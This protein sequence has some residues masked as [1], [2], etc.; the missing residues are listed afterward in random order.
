MKI[1]DCR[2]RAIPEVKYENNG[3]LKY[4]V[5]CSVCHKKTPVCDSLRE[6]V[7]LWNKTQGRALPSEMDS[8]EQDR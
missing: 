2:C 8:A 6:A 3:I 7:T 5:M 4:V 1:Y